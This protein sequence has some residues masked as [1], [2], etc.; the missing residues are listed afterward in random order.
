MIA[1]PSLAFAQTLGAFCWLQIGGFMSEIADEFKI[2]VVEAIKALCL[3][4]PQVTWLAH[5]VMHVVIALCHLG[6]TWTVV[7]GV[8]KTVCNWHANVRGLHSQCSASFSAFYQ[9]S[10]RSVLVAPG[11][12]TLLPSCPPIKPA[13]IITLHHS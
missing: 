11:W 9:N 2:V 3:K 8:H 7:V 5:L 1:S 13:L 12:H 6:L 4:F 10:S